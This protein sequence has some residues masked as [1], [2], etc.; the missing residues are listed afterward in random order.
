ML[1]KVGI[2]EDMNFPCVEVVHLLCG[3]TWKLI[4]MHQILREWR[5]YVMSSLR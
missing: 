5:A 1:N 4:V 2:T 3:N